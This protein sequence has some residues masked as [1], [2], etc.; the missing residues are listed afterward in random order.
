MTI[1][2]LILGALMTGVA[3]LAAVNAAQ[4]RRSKLVDRVTAYIEFGSRP[5]PMT[6]LG[7]DFNV[8]PRQS[9]LSS[10]VTKLGGMFASR[11]GAVGEDAIREQL[12]MAG[13]Y[14]A[15]PR[16]VIGYRVLATIGLPAVA[17]LLL[18]VH[19]K[20]GIAV[21]VLALFIGWIL[22]LTIVQRKARL[23]VSEIDRVL[24]DLIDLLLVMIEA[25]LSFTSALRLA[26]EQFGP[27]LSD[28]LRLTLQ[29]QTMG[30]GIDEALAHMAMRADTP[31]MKAFVRAMTQ[32]QKMGISLGQVMRGLS[33]EMR[34]RRRSTAEEKAQKTPVLMLF[35]LV[36]LIFPAM[37]IVLMTPAVINMFHSLSHGL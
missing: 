8:H 34:H 11:V 35:P 22:P 5:A 7:I 19:S 26:S 12:M 13:M 28:E 16:T 23:R 37:F 1:V 15:S 10:L 25:G 4:A 29:E 18:G 20:L 30:L 31:G 33:H 2:L 9:P 6:E 3:V 24:P 21:V 36:F 17:A 32:G 14:T 27:P